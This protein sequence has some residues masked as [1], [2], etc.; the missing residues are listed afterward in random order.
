MAVEAKIT[1]LFRDAERGDAETS[2]SPSDALYAD[3]K[4]R[5]SNQLRRIAG[6]PGML[7]LQP[8]ALVTKPTFAC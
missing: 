1:E 5:A 7:T 3:L 8:T 6:R 2:I 4:Q